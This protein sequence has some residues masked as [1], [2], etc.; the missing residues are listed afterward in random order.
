[1][2]TNLTSTNDTAD[3]RISK[4]LQCDAFGNSASEKMVD[5]L[6]SRLKS[7]KSDQSLDGPPGLKI[8]IEDWHSKAQ[9]RHKRK[10]RSSYR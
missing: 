3:N 2:E 6:M 8:L 9:Y 1:M 5:S 7:L 10:G 4:E